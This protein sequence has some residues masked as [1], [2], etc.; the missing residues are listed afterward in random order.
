MGADIHTYI[1]VQDNTDTW[2]CAWHSGL[3]WTEWF[4]SNYGPKDPKQRYSED[5]TGLQSIQER[6]YSL[7][8]LLSNVRWDNL[9]EKHGIGTS[10]GCGIKGWP[11]TIA[12]V[13]KPE[14]T[15]VDY[16]SHGYLT[17]ADLRTL[18]ASLVALNFAKPDETNEAVQAKNAILWIDDVET[19]IKTLLGEKPLIGH[20]I[21][22][23]P[24]DEDYDDLNFMITKDISGHRTLE[25]N[26]FF[27]RF[28]QPDPTK[29]RILFCYDN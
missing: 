9:L 1:E 2:H 25:N 22:S 23:V 18:R 3:Y 28:T 26:D 17:L 8:G 6:D 21:G 5:P 7:F 13:L 12:P 29:V 19:A 4:M 14:R 10:D 27:L 11:D 24:D 16:H 20:A 15:D